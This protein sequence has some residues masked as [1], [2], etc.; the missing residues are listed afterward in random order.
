MAH[1]I[2]KL[3][4]P[5]IEINSKNVAKSDIRI[6]FHKLKFKPKNK[7]Y[8]SK[9]NVED[10]NI[11]KLPTIDFDLNHPKKCFLPNFLPNNA[12]AES[13]NINGIAKIAPN[14]NWILVLLIISNSPKIPTK[15]N[16]TPYSLML[17]FLSKEQLLQNFETT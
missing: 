13:P 16:K 4:I 14:L 6:K 5:F 2:V 10:I 3:S 1:G 15:K 12:A 9:N 8:K 11:A 17:S 7:L